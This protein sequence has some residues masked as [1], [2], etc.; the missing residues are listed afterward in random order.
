[1]GWWAATVSILI[2]TSPALAADGL[3]FPQ[4]LHL[5]RSIK[6]PLSETTRTL[7]QYCTGHRIITIAG[8]SVVIAD[9]QRQELTEIDRLAQTYSVTSFADLARARGEAKP[10]G[11]K[12]TARPGVRSAAA[13]SVE[14]FDLRNAGTGERRSMRISVDRSIPLSRGALEALIGAAFPAA[15][16]S[17]HEVLVDVAR[18]TRARQQSASVDSA[19]D[20]YALPVEEVTTYEFEGAV[21]TRESRIIKIQQDLPPPE[22]VAIPPAARRVESKRITVPRELRSLDELPRRVVTP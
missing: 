9:Y 22:L 7:E 6:D 14:S 20:T 2:S 11:M 19:A 4:P 10:D 13:G 16:R 21:L 12:W 18:G 3:L 5:T 17:E 15:R 1:M 8:S